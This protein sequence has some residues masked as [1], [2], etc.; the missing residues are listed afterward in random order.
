MGNRL[1]VYMLLVPNSVCLVHE[2]IHVCK[3]CMATEIMDRFYHSILQIKIHFYT[4]YTSPNHTL[5]Y[6]LY[7][8]V[9]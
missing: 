2:V 6:R 3:L 8:P 4:I 1:T 5:N 9:I 7:L